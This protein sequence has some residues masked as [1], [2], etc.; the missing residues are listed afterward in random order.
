MNVVIRVDASEKIGSGH[1]FRTFL[2]A[3][4]LK[5]NKKIHFISNNLKKEY[6][7]RLKSENFFHHNIKLKKNSS[8]E[9][10]NKTNQILRKLSNPVDLLIV[11][12]YKLGIEWENITKSYVKKLM[13]ID[14]F[15]RK[16][17]CDIYLNYTN[18]KFHK[19]F[20]P[21]K[22]L[23]LI[24]PKYIILNTKY[25]Q[26]NK[27]EDNK[28]KFN[29]FVFM[30]GA[31]RSNFTLK[32]FNYFK[33]PIFKN[34][35][36]KFV[37]GINNKRKNLFIKMGKKINNFNIYYNLK[38]LKSLLSSS[39]FCISNGGQVIWE[40]IY[41]KIPNIIFCK[42]KYRNNIIFKNQKILHS[43]IF[44]INKSNMFQQYLK[45]TDSLIRDYS[46]PK[47]KMLI[48]NKIVDGR[49]LQRILQKIK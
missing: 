8:V 7:I 27:K 47:K 12:S 20:L 35:K 21:S 29:I 41:N 4:Y 34:F 15:F 38:N 49:G 9:D 24:G 37:I 6:L 45:K 28:K 11:D 32:L 36:F 46:S 42:D 31:D 17:N 10:A 22:C 23:K 2:L 48:K 25:T 14:D 16:H 26:K 33:K 18:Y 40:I 19:N 43:Y 44:E 3:K 13:V 30:G 1:F 5:K 39:S